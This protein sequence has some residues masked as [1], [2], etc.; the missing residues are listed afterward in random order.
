MEKRRTSSVGPQQQMAVAKMSELPNKQEQ[1]YEERLFLV[2]VS[3]P[4]PLQVAESISSYDACLMRQIGGATLHR[5]HIARSNA[6][7]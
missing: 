1:E 5:D 6:V 4:E 2:Y 3:L 7:D